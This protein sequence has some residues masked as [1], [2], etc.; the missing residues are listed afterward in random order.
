MVLPTSWV[1]QR[2]CWP[3]R[4][5]RL[6]AWSAVPECPC[7][8]P[9]RSL[10]HHPR[11]RLSRGQG[12]CQRSQGLPPWSVSDRL[13]PGWQADGAVAAAN[14]SFVSVTKTMHGCY[15]DSKWNLVITKPCIEAIK[16]V[17]IRHL[18]LCTYYY[19]RPWGISKGGTQKTMVLL[20]QTHLCSD[21][22]F[23]H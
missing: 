23:V 3:C 2:P 10:P 21:F 6:L 11:E 9:W 15:V 18:W 4:S 7:L 13:E 20:R 22:Q 8:C 19:C 12:R 1:R 17:V 5:L 14:V 16:T